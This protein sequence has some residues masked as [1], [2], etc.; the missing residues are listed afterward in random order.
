[1]ESLVIEERLLHV[2]DI[3][4]NKTFEVLGLAPLVLTLLI[5]ITVPLFVFE[6]NDAVLVRVRY[7][8]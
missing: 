8:T 7:P 5:P 6:C 3:I 4:E 2:K 1:M